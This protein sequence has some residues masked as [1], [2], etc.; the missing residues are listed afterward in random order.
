MTSMEKNALDEVRQ[1]ARKTAALTREAEDMLN[2]LVQA[3][4]DERRA[5]LEDL[6]N[7]LQRCQVPGAY[8]LHPRRIRRRRRH[9]SHRMRPRPGIAPSSVRSPAPVVNAA[10]AFDAAVGGSL[11]VRRR[12]PPHDF[13]S[14]VSWLRGTDS[15]QYICLEEDSLRWL[16]RRG[17]IEVRPLRSEA[18]SRR[19]R[20]KERFRRHR[21][22]C[23][24]TAELRF[25]R[26]RSIVAHQ[27]RGHR[28]ALRSEEA[29][30]RLVTRR[31]SANLPKAAARL[32]MAAVSLSRWVG[33]ATFEAIG[34]RYRR[35]TDRSRRGTTECATAA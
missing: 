28:I 34:V 2:E 30:L 9:T 15:V 19:D 31:N 6:A 16:V 13:S 8:G 18:T 35:L 11:C 17:P 3:D 10:A 27:A 7:P 21:R 25:Q 29:G 23:A 32:G 22:A 1:L 20:R 4:D 24:A 33:G 26:A 14:L 12:R 5:W